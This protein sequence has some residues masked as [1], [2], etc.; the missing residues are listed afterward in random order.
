MMKAAND[1][2]R[3]AALRALDRVDGGA[4]ADIVLDRELAGFNA[5][6]AG[7]ATEIVYGVLRWRI[8]IDRVIDSFSVIKTGKLERSVL[9][10]L[11]MGAYQLL[12]LTRVPPSAAINET[13]NLVKSGGRRKAGFVNAVLRKID[14]QKGAQA[15]AYDDPALRISIECSHPLWLVRRWME[16]FGEAEAEKICRANLEVPPR[17]LRANSLVVTRES[18][19]RGLAPEGVDARKTHLSP[20]GVEVVRG[21]VSPRDRRFYIQDEASQLIAHLV[22]PEPGQTVLD[23]CSA[24]GGK[25]THMAELMKNKGRICALERYAGRLKSVENAARRLGIT[26]IETMEADSTGP[27]PTGPLL[28]DAIL[29]DAPCSGLGVIGRSPDIKYRRTHLD[30]I[31]NG[32]MQRRLLANLAGYLKTGGCMVYSVCTFE[33]E[34]TDSVIEDFLKSREDFVLEGAGGYVP[35]E[36][37]ALVDEPGFFRTYPH[38]HRVDGFFAARLKKIS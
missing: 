1:S 8:K 12:F 18:L 14:S 7:L 25:A 31:E 13:V 17:T 38:R 34:E 28:F 4:Y 30:V 23:A 19:I 35:E 3:R 21:R 2:P 5:V 37:G 11:R 29:C 6:D 32:Q 9:N 22:S 10:A 24:P 27:L 36:C 33:P 15:A 16:R 26:I 20:D